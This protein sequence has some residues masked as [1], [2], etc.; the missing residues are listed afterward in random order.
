MKIKDP[1][2]I[3][4]I[5]KIPLE[6]ITP[7]YSHDALSQGNCFPVGEG[8]EKKADDV[9]INVLPQESKD[10]LPQKQLQYHKDIR[11]DRIEFICVVLGFVLMTVVLFLLDLILVF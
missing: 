3:N 5:L 8:V 11:Q 1:D 7:V 9:S 6:Q 4:M 2:V 10:V